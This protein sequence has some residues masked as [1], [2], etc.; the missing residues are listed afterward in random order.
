MLTGWTE[1]IAIWN[2]HDG[3]SQTRSV[4]GIV[5]AITQQQLNQ[6]KHYKQTK[7]KKLCMASCNI[8]IANKAIARHIIYKIA[9]IQI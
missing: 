9:Q 6:G 4:I 3:W 5:T 7:A 8:K 2:E 1:P